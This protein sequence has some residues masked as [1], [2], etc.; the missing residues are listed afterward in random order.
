MPLELRARRI[1]ERLEQTYANLPPLSRDEYDHIQ[2]LAACY[3]AGMDCSADWEA[4][5]ASGLHDRYLL[6][7]A[8]FVIPDRVAA[9]ASQPL[10]AD[11]T[12]NLLVALATAEEAQD[13]LEAY[14]GAAADPNYES[15]LKMML[16]GADLQ[17][18]IICDTADLSAGRHAGMPYDRAA[19]VPAGP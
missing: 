17:Q 10:G 11:R 8:T 16:I 5:R 3:G 7:G 6:R 19:P 9:A 4:A 13:A 14:P 12:N 2:H 18:A 1:A 15:P